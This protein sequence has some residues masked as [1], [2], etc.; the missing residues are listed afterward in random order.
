MEKI[1]QS[2]VHNSALCGATRFQVPACAK[3]HGVSRSKALVRSIK[4]IL[5][6]LFS[7]IILVIVI[8]IIFRRQKRSRTPSSTEISL[9]ME[10]R[11][12]SYIELVRGTNSFS[13]TNLLGR[14]SFGS[15]FK[16]TLDD[17]L[18]VAAK[19]FNLQLEGA[20]KS[21]DTE[22]KI[23]STIRHR[24]LV[25]IIGCCSNTEFK[26]L[27][28]AYM[29]N[30]SLEKWLYSDTYCLD[31]GQRLNIAIDVALALEYLHCGH[32][33]PVVHCDMKPTNV[34]LDLDMT[35]HVGDFGISKLFDEGETMV[36]T[37]TL[38]TIGYAAPG[39]E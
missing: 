27:I 19:V 20:A 16:V 8:T 28:L 31:L 37:K 3:K 12:V 23:L 26:A 15:V 36:Q 32:T 10:W 21:F 18:N 24:N 34:L 2:F 17:G 4:Y 13:E 9:G 1:T 30:G 33:F 38:A 25:R 22:S 14:G 11:R 39:D 35:A 29:P 5:P 7:I 6:S